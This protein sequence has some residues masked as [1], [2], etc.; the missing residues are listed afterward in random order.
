MHVSCTVSI[1]PTGF[2][3]LLNGSGSK[4]GEAAVISV[5]LEVQTTDVCVGFWYYMLGASVSSLDLLV[6]TVCSPPVR[7]CVR[8]LLTCQLCAPALSLI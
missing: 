5:P 3:L 8:Q 6:Q 4:D 2:Y 1:P 7:R